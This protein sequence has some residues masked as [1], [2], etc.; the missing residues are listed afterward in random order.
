[1]KRSKEKAA[2]KP[3]RS[4]ANPALEHVFALAL[5]HHRAGRLQQ[6]QNLYRQTLAIEPQH[7]QSLHYLGVLA[8]QAG[9]PD[10]AVD[11]IGQAIALE[12]RNPES[13]YNIGLAFRALGRMDEV[14]AHCR[15][16]VAL[17]PDYADAHLNLG[18]ALK[19]QGK[20]DDASASYRR[21]AHLRPDS[22]DAHFNLANV[23]AEQGKAKEALAA[24]ERTLA[25]KP[26]HAQ[27][28]NNLGTLL[29]SLE[30]GEEAVSCFQRA[31]L[32]DPDLPESYINLGRA[33]LSQG[34]VYESCGVINRAFATGAAQNRIEPSLDLVRRILETEESQDTKTLFVQC[35]RTLSSVPDLAYLRDLLIRALNEPWGRP[36]ELARAVV[37]LL[38]HNAIIGTAVERSTTAWPRRLSLQ[39]LFGNAGLPAVADD[40]L[41]HTLLQSTF[42]RD[43]A[44]ERFLTNV[45][46]ALLQTALHTSEPLDAHA[47][48][49]SC[50]LARH[51]FI[52]EY[53]FD[54]SDDESR[55]AGALRDEVAAALQS[56]GSVSP[57]KLAAVAAYFPLHSLPGAE[58]LL[59]HAWPQPVQTAL[60]QQVAESLQERQ[61]AESIPAL[62]AI[63]DDVSRAVQQQYEQNPY[64]RWAKA[65]PIGSATALDEYLGS[66]FQA[67]GF[68]PL[69]RENVDFLIAGCG[70]GQ[71]STM[72]AQQF[73]SAQ[74]LAIDLSRSSLGYAAR[75]TQALGLSNVE[76]AQADILQ[77]ASLGRMFDAIDSTGVLHHLADPFA[78][79]RVLLSLLRPNGVM[80]LGFYSALGRG[81]I[82]AVRRFVSEQGYRPTPHD[83]RKA[84]QQLS[85][86]PDGTPQKTI[87]AASDF[88]CMS[89]CRDLLFHVQETGYTLPQLKDFLAAENLVFLGFETTAGVSQ[90]YGQ[91][92]PDDTAMVDLD[93]W[94][95][96]ETENPR[97]FFNM[98]QF[99]VQKPA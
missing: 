59:G 63:D 28:L 42:V 47:L 88:F 34:Q 9:R 75:M 4:P 79:W 92:F 15:R 19:Q 22:A 21:V 57:L 81:D 70:T 39:E 8:L 95:A 69:G 1:M 54:V 12:N 66:N 46:A 86:F 16:A 33:L 93:R 2:G 23:F 32:H 7:A 99:W 64:P 17:K 73:P 52:N 87:T 50:A 76:Y 51:C 72:L 58:T 67:A 62:T 78:G 40:T 37:S 35:V 29:V 89:E 18:N 25:L 30:R 5:Q 24:Y 56:G 61:I 84:R 65:A 90:L 97:I 85:A 77:L 26:D 48:P 49:L 6:A 11:L 80:R 43:V 53:V 94:H 82:D 68:R 83:I 71:H 74:I 31:V 44:F 10:T 36:A 41:L 3:G 20:L 91:K 27:A 38:R 55:L 45:R 98:Y 14:I 60:T 96:V 13:H